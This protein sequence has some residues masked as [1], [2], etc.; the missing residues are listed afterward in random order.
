[1]SNSKKG[2][3]IKLDEMINKLECTIQAS[4]SSVA[5]VGG[6]N[7]V[8][9][10]FL[11]MLK[12]FRVRLNSNKV[13]PVKNNNS[14][15]SSVRPPNSSRQSP[16]QSQNSPRQS[17]VQSQNS[18][19][20]SP[21][22]SHNSPP[23]PIDLNWAV[24]P[25]I[26]TM[27]TD[28]PD[29]IIIDIMN[30]LD[31]LDAIKFLLVSQSIHKLE[32]KYIPTKTNTKEKL[33]RFIAIILNQMMTKKYIGTISIY[34]NNP[35]NA[36]NIDEAVDPEDLI[37]S[38]ISFDMGN[39]SNILKTDINF[40]EDESPES[41]ND[42]EGFDYNVDEEQKDIT[43]TIRLVLSNPIKSFDIEYGNAY[44]DYKSPK[45]LF[46]I[47]DKLDIAEKL[48]ELTNGFPTSNAQPSMPSPY[49]PAQW[50]EHTLNAST[51]QRILKTKGNKTLLNAIK[52]LQARQNTTF[53]KA[54]AK[55]NADRAA[56]A[57]KIAH[58]EATELREVA[59]IIA[60]LEARTTAAQAARVARAAQAAQATQAVQAAQEAGKPKAGKPKAVKTKAVKPK[61]VKPKTV[62]PKAVKSV[63]PTKK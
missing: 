61:A 12:Y 19:R 3:I 15:Q 29:D 63:K 14:R 5:Q 9:T 33:K 56:L 60:E 43:D 7:D 45:L 27:L 2:A 24:D 31:I 59:R 41:V 47:L 51:C 22:Q 13:K 28:L 8:V 23:P 50:T 32:K 34:I 38:T 17:P 10:N 35:Q 1:M 20:Q 46:K 26:E 39:D 40:E 16:V 54:S 37:K 30:K 42:I 18:P 36:N 11:N 6:A 48:N 4:N 62:K 58:E 53:Q 44:N 55:T 57:K 21:V 25:P 49:N 52:E